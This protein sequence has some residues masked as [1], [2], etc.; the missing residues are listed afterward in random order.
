[1]E[2]KVWYYIYRDGV[3]V[4]FGLKIVKVPVHEDNIISNRRNLTVNIVDEAPP[5]S[6]LA[7]SEYLPK[8]LTAPVVVEFFDE[9]R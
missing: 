1:M 8:Y 7:V 5:G 6:V 4:P 9:S 3:P 2:F